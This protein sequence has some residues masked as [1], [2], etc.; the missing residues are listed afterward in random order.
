MRT[1]AAFGLGFVVQPIWAAARRRRAERL[2][3]V[4]SVPFPR[5]Y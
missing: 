3:R 4:P 5:T 1:V 2:A